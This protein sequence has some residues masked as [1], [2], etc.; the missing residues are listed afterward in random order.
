[1][2]SEFADIATF[3]RPLASEQ[4]ASLLLDDGAH[5]SFGQNER[6]SVTADMLIEG[7]HFFANG[8]PED[9]AAKALGCNLSD[10]AAMG[11][12]PK[13]YTLSIG[14]PSWADSAWLQRFCAGLQKLQTKYGFSLI[15]GDTVASDR[16][17][18]NITMIGT[19]SQDYNNPLRS[20][21]REGDEIWITGTVGD[22]YLGL[23]SLLGKVPSCSDE[24]RVFLEGRYWR[25]IPRFIMNSFA[26]GH[27][28]CADIS[29]GA[30]ADIRQICRASSVG[31]KV[32][33]ENMPLSAPFMAVRGQGKD[34]LIE[35][36]TGG[37]DYELILCASAKQMEI[38][39]QQS[40]GLRFTKV[41]EVTSSE[42][43]YSICYRGSPVELS[44]LG[45]E[46]L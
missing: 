16:L 30:L 38:I 17:V 9:I 46:H 25:P 45:W 33:L 6:V 11:A 23:Q 5:L 2:S 36:A 34:A 42:Q 18:L 14:R 13:Y 37:D 35:A 8:A 39:R 27:V 44:Q 32:E 4:G 24:D 28:A 7:V 20:C 29:D 26:G 12:I 10:V 1:M 31:A 43:G 21:A 40:A 3:L 41:G 22:G 19:Q 15:G